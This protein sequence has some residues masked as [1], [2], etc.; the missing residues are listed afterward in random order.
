MTASYYNNPS[1]P[2]CPWQIHGSCDVLIS[3][4][5]ICLCLTFLLKSMGNFS[6]CLII[7]S[8]SM[9]RY[10][11]SI[12][13]CRSF[14]YHTHLLGVLREYWNFDGPRF[15]I[16]PMEHSFVYFILLLA[17][18]KIVILFLF[19]FYVVI[20]FAMTNY[21]WKISDMW[22]RVPTYPWHDI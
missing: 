8:A 9:L 3:P 21:P 6:L 18:F 1:I 17:C 14:L 2:Q 19:P 12:L 15:P 7:A 4:S 5:I 16:T 22:H 20:Y 11:D 10:G 13:E